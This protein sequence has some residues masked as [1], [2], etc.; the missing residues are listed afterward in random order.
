MEGEEVIH[1]GGG[2]GYVA[3]DGVKAPRGK[4]GSVHSE[5]LPSKDSFQQF[6]PL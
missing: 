4:G 3:E 6:F 1:E 5:A 2:K